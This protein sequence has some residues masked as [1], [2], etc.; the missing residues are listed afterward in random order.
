MHSTPLRISTHLNDI[1]PDY[2][3]LSK[4]QGC[5]GSEI[6]VRLRSGQAFFISFRM[7]QG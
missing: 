2:F 7:T 6:P 5:E 3:I 4:P 1:G